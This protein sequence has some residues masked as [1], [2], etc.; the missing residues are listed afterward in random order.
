MTGDKQSD[1]KELMK[2]RGNG[3]LITPVRKQKYKISKE[4]EK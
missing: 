3:K 1:L 4:I 2:K